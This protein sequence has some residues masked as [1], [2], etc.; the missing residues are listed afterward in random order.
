LKQFRKS[1]SGH[2]FTE[3]EFMTFAL[4]QKNIV[5]QD[6]IDAIN[7]SYQAM[8]NRKGSVSVTSI[9]EFH[10]QL[11]GEGSEI[12]DSDAATNTARSQASAI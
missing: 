5:T 10:N 2:A 7:Q 6:Q 9:T 4:V 3:M 8:A 11:A 12:A 1:A